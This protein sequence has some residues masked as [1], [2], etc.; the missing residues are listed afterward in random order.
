MLEPLKT[1]SQ[2]IVF[3][4]GAAFMADGYARETGK[5][6]VCCATTGPGTTNLITG[7]H[8]F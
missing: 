4:T 1:M 6:G 7:I 3:L 5:I 2:C 8:I